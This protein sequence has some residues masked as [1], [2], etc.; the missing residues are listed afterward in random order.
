MAEPPPTGMIYIASDGPSRGHRPGSY[1]LFRL[2]SHQK[3][4][5]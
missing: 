5:P 3:E 2:L 4:N 1:F